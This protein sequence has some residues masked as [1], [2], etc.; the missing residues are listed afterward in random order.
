MFAI[1]AFDVHLSL[2][3]GAAVNALILVR[4][5]HFLAGITWVGLLY[6]F[7]LVST[8]FL[9]ELDSTTR[10]KMVPL[11]MPRALWW[12]RWSSV[13]TVLAGISYWMNIVSSDAHN[14]NV[15]PGRAIWSFFVIWTV[16]FAIEMGVLMSPA[17]A[18]RKGPVFGV[19]CGVAVFAAAYLYLALN[20]DGWESNRLLA[21]GVGGGIGWFML[22]NVWGIVWR[23]QKKIILWSRG[24]P[25]GAMPPEMTRM[26]RLSFL[27]SR[28]NFALSFPMLF[29]MGAAS[30]YP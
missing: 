6:F 16:A 3:E 30:H 17:E 20:S 22:L 18:L 19:I 14:A 23:M 12:F 1:A 21:I 11:L 28:L 24:N 8:P 5:I 7:N 29:F 13:V 25:N 4:W 15:S 26:A 27:A 10:A 2:P 9:K